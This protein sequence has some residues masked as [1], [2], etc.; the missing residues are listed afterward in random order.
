ML[1]CLGRNDESMYEKGNIDFKFYFGCSAG[2]LSV[3]KLSCSV[4]G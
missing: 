2:L 1:K 4:K 3:L